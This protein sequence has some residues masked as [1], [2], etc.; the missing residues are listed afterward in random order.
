MKV[1]YQFHPEIIKTI[2]MIADYIAIYNNNYTNH[3]LFVIFSSPTLG[4]Y[5]DTDYH[6]SPAPHLKVMSIM[7]IAMYNNASYN[8]YYILLKTSQQKAS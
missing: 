1:G 3:N 5:M 8:S 4:F 7:Y 2:I 6:K